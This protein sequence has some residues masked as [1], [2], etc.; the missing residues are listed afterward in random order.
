MKKKLTTILTIIIFCTSL[1]CNY[2]VIDVYAYTN[3][4][5]ENTEIST[6][7]NSSILS[8]ITPKIKYLKSP[9]KKQIKI[10]YNKIPNVEY[11]HIVISTD[12]LGRNIYKEY[13]TTKTSYTIKKL[14]SK[15]TYYIKIR[16]C[17]GV[18]YDTDTG[19]EFAKDTTR[20]SGTKK[21]KVK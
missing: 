8:D 15:K 20:F 11:Y 1:L 17:I 10:K 2:A 6:D 19:E 13:K 4:E 14:K 18:V 3:S 16:G 12:K 9:K 21:I 5:S 7:G